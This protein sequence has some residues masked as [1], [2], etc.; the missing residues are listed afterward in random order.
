VADAFEAF[1]ALGRR[2]IRVQRNSQAY[3]GGGVKFNF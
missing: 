3:F 2:V 1:G